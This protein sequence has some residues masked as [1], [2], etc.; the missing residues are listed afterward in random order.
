MRQPPRKRTSALI[1]G[2]PVEQELRSLLYQNVCNRACAKTGEG[3]VPE[4]QPSNDWFSIPVSYASGSHLGSHL[5]TDAGSMPRFRLDRSDVDTLRAERGRTSGEWCVRKG[6]VPVRG[7]RDLGESRAGD[8]LLKLSF[9]E[10]T[11]NSA[12]PKID[13]CLSV[14]RN[15]PGQHDIADLKGAARFQHPKRFGKRGLFVW[16]QVEYAV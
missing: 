13:I 15:R 7:K 16:R 10:S 8:N 14:R 11:A 6:V 3:H 5:S 1:S 12:S 2:K 9:Q 4:H